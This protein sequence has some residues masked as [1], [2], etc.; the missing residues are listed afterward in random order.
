MN[1]R[2]ATTLAAMLV[3]TAATL[4]V[5]PLEG[6]WSG[7]LMKMPL[8]VHL[9]NDS[10]CLYSPAQTADSIPLSRLDMTGDTLHF[11]VG[12]IGLSY[13]GVFSDSKI[14]GT[15]HQ[16]S[17]YRLTFFPASAADASLY[18]P[19]TPRPPFFYSVEDLTFPSGDLT[20]AG[21]LTTPYQRPFG[22][23]VLVSGSGAQT[24]DEE[25]AGHKPF[26]VIADELTRSGWA[27]LRYD[28]RGAGGSERGKPTD[29]TL[30]FA[31]DAMAAVS[32]VRKRFPG[33]P[34]G[35]AGHS[36]GGTIAMIN[37]AQY[38][39]SIDFIISMAGM[40]VDG[41]ELMIRQNEMMLELAGA[42]EDPA[43]HADLEATFRIVASDMPEAEAAEKIDS[44]MSRTLSDPAIRAG[45]VRGLL[46]PWYR[47]FIRLTPSVYL[48]RIKCPMLAINGTWDVQVEAAPN[49]K[50]I[51]DRVATAKTVEL[52]GLNHLFQEAPSRSQSFNYAAISQ[53]ISPKALK[54]ITDFLTDYLRSRK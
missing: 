54:A 30:D 19:Q 14:S 2:T 13:T 51:S 4:A 24:R 42:P 7:E 34:V 5:A 37:A 52:A 35:I 12:A 3:S 23:I 46:T 36:E 40:A 8:V 18:R 33:L 47:R 43:L 22:A 38:P 41:S 10:G 21:T 6:W 15:L 9:G 31:Q 48:D 17:D 49:L 32:T 1:T 29:T 45:S 53:T 28:D 16:G 26:A 27:V 11:E 25:I 50:A 44:I 39:D 20:M